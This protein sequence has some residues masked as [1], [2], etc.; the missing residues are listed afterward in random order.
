MDSGDD[1]V[2]DEQTQLQPPLTHRRVPTEI[3]ARYRESELLGVG[4]MGEVV[5]AHDAW[6]GRD[7]A[8]KRMRAVQ[9]SA[10]QRRRFMREAQIQA[11]LDHP[12][13]PPVHELAY[14]SHDQPYFVMKRLSGA[15]LA[16]IIDAGREARFSQRELLHAFINVCLALELAHARGIVHRDL[17]PENIMLGDYGE[18]YVLDWGIAKVPPEFDVAPLTPESDAEVTAPGAVIGTPRY[19]SPEQARGDEVDARS[20]VYALGCVLYEIVIGARVPLDGRVPLQPSQLVPDIAPEL[21]DVVIAATQ[22]RPSQRP[23]SARELGNRLQRFLD[24]DRD[25]ETRSRLAAEHLERARKAATWRDRDEEYQ[26][27]AFR[28]AG[29]ALALAP[30]LPGAAELVSRLMLEPPRVVPDE[31][32]REISE[33]QWASIRRQARTALFAYT[34]YIGFVGHALWSGVVHPGYLVPFVGLVGAM[35]VIAYLGTRQLRWPAIGA[36]ATVACN[37]GLVAVI[38]R[39]YSPFLIAPGVAAVTCVLLM[40][41]PLFRSARYVAMLVAVMIAAIILPFL[42]EAAGVLAPTME[43]GDGRLAIVDAVLE[44]RPVPVA[45]GLCVFAAGL[46]VLATYVTRALA[47]NDE[48]ARI[49]LRFQAWQLRQLVGEP[50]S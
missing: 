20:D 34:L 14:D 48:R 27:V 1:G 2:T 17:K 6:L 46:I 11:R 30:E 28:E 16:S 40:G 15:T 44:L 47:R 39:M 8:I 38:A 18:V 42:L 5:A 3:A 29:R 43:L 45:I 19:M 33:D 36:A 9:P 37:A 41:S 13:V 49:Q 26:R 21:D 10:L 24:G 23:A 31:L 7:V 22:P 35:M 25:T 50:P 12:S 4:G 32:A